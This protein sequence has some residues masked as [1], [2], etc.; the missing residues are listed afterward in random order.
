LRVS[1][2]VT[3]GVRPILIIFLV[4]KTFFLITVDT[5]I[6]I[7]LGINIMNFSIIVVVIISN[8]RDFIIF[9]VIT[10]IWICLRVA[11]QVLIVEVGF[12]ILGD[13]RGG[14]GQIS[15]DIY[16]LVWTYSSKKKLG[17][18]PFFFFLFSPFFRVYKVLLTQ[19]S[20]T[21]FS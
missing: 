15:G 14:V 3:V 8:N 12:I 19:D 10:C 16:A 11:V 17:Q 7:S 21:F 6:V 4:G 1:V 5:I 9:F 20:C 18:I 13:C 2:S